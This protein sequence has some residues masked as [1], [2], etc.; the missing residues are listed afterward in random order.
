MSN[1]TVVS[2]NTK[3]NKERYN[4]LVKGWWNWVYTRNCDDNNS[5]AKLNVTFLRDDIIGSRL[6]LPAG[7]SSTPPNLQPCHTKNVT[8]NAGSNIFLPVYHVNTVVDHPYGDGR[9]CG[10]I[11]RC[12]ESSRN[13]LGNLYVQWAK[14]KVNG[15]K[16]QD[17]TNNL[18]NHYFESDEFTLTVKGKHSLNRE[19]GFSLGEGRHQGV[20]FGTYLLLNN[21][22]PGTYE[23]DFGGKATNYRTRAVYNLTVE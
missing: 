11:E 6:V 7:I 21:F 4:E 20:A 5:D 8:T 10:N 18:N 17:I 19:Q 15:G 16:A 14:V 12:I 9:E 1:Y 22:Q 3:A 23:L 2:P 13:D